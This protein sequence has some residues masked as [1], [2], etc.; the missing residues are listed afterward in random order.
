MG[1]TNQEVTEAMIDIETL[2]TED[3]SICYQV[4][5][6]LFRGH[7]V[8]AQRQWN[9]DIQE[10]IDAGRSISADT[11]AFHLRI[12]QGLGTSMAMADTDVA[13]FKAQLRSFWRR[14]FN[15]KY[16]WA[17]G[18]MDF[19]V[20][21]DLIGEDN[22]PW[23]WY[24]QMELRTLIRETGADKPEPPHNALADCILQHGQLLQCREI[25]DA[26]RRQSEEGNQQISTQADT[27]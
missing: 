19:D 1:D 10:Q 5:I 6:I 4:G 14:N 26:A 27:E 15:P 18:N 21:E 25:I 2:D 22:C 12:P 23:E 7:E 3:T 24:N 11:L 17:K 9:L 13:T 8:V 20:L 16:W